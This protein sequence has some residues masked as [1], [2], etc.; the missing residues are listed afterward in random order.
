MGDIGGN[1]VTAKAYEW[2]RTCQG[3]HEKCPGP[4]KS[5]LPTQIIDIGSKTD[6]SQ[7]RLCLSSLV[8]AEHM[9]RSAP[10]GVVF[11]MPT[12]TKV[13]GAVNARDLSELQAV[14]SSTSSQ[15]NSGN[16]PQTQAPS[17]ANQPH[18]GAHR[19]PDMKPLPQLFG[20]ESVRIRSIGNRH[21]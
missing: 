8:D 4:T 14:D 15:S 13:R 10:A 6:N 21:T 16:I 7:A 12:S 2:L 18:C 5:I 1:F 17:Q 19:C 11:K 9:Q 20:L 3:H